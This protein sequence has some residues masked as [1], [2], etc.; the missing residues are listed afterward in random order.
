MPVKVTG[1]L[2]G[3]RVKPT[4]MQYLT[5]WRIQLGTRLLRETHR[6]DRTGCGLRLRGRLL[7]RLQTHGRHATGEVATESGG[8]I[9][10]GKYYYQLKPDSKR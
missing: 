3:L 2:A 7:V 8:G 5:N 1:W 4:P 9:R 6:D 10:L